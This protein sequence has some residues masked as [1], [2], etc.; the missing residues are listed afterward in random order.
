MSVLLA[1]ILPL[2]KVLPF[3][4]IATIPSTSSRL[5]EATI[6]GLV[7]TV[8]DFSAFRIL[9]GQGEAP[10]KCSV[11]QKTRTRVHYARSFSGKILI[12]GWKGVFSARGTQFSIFKQ[13][14]ENLIGHFY[15]RDVKVV[16]RQTHLTSDAFRRI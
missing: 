10:E 6:A 13:S 15:A 12:E 16:S 7:E 3:S 8:S 5:P 9:V 14:R 4:P 11:G 1:R 2:A